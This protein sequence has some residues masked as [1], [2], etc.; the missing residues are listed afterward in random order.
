[1][2]FNIKM[3]GLT[4]LEKMIVEAGP[5]ALLLASQAVANESQIIFRNSQRIVPVATGTLRRSGVLDAP[6]QSGKSITVEMGYGG[7]A[8]AY[9]LKQHEDLSLRHKEGKSAKY[10]E[11]PLMERAKNLREVLL[12]K[13]QRYFEFRK[14]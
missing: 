12:R 8:N 13:M 9:A 2:K 14:K 3:I 10:L 7:A 6:K 1:M 5:E 11:K 4:E